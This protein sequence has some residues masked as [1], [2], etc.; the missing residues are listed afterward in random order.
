M[1]QAK[2]ATEEAA[3]TRATA[4]G[5]TASPSAT[6]TDPFDPLILSGLLQTDDVPADNRE[7]SGADSHP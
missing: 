6:F 7:Y 5:A 4:T 3:K 1:T 2:A